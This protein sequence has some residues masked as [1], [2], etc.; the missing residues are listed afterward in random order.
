MIS[1][2]VNS[3]YQLLTTNHRTDVRRA[4]HPLSAATMPSTDGSPAD[5]PTRAGWHG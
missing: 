2:L 3:E 5:L 4:I 1:W